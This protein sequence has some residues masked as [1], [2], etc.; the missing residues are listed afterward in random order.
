MKVFDP[1]EAVILEN[2]PAKEFMMLKSGKILLRVDASENITITLGAI[3]AGFSFGW[4]SLIPGRTY[5]S[6]AVCAEKC[7]GFRD[8]RRRTPR[9]YGE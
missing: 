4:S 7:E 5:T 2:Q 3:N 8:F 6:S 1:K 9:N